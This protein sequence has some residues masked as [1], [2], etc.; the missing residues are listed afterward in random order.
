MMIHALPTG[1]YSP[2]K[3]KKMTDEF[4]FFVPHDFTD[5]P[6]EYSQPIDEDC[7]SGEIPEDATV[8]GTL[9]EDGKR[10]ILVS[11]VTTVNKPFFDKNRAMMTRYINDRLRDGS[12]AR[13]VPFAFTTRHITYLQRNYKR[14]N[15]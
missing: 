2:N 14:V 10:R 5:E 3:E 12:M 1:F 11:E 13:I 9:T 15:F 6:S 8:T 4:D 7:S